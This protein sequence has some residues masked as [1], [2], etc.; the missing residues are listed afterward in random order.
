ME[1]KIFTFRGKTLE[2]LQ[3]M[4]IREFAKYVT[5][6]ERRT[7][8]RNFDL[9]EKYVKRWKE[10]QKKGKTIRTHLRDLIIV[11]Q[12]IGMTIHVH[13]GKEFVP[14]K[15]NEEMLGHR[16]GEFALTRKEVKHGAPGIGATR[17]SAYLA[18]K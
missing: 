11:P 4:S 10:Y 1:K 6:R 14:V 18:V 3:Q 8:L 2:E 12:M 13:N 5:S 9:I 16:L 7:I 17:S 15:I